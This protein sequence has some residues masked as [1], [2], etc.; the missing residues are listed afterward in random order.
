VAGCFGLE[1]VR[2][3]GSGSGERRRGGAS[4]TG[5]VNSSAGQPKCEPAALGRSMAAASV[6]PEVGDG[7]SG[8]GGP[9]R[10]GG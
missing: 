6:S 5:R 2:E 3:V 8:P 9:S 1:G 10:S 7:G 4:I